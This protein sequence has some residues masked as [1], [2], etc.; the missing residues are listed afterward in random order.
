M[1]D[2]NERSRGKRKRKLGNI[3][4]PEEP[5]RR[6]TTVREYHRA[7]ESKVLPHVRRGSNLE[8]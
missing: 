3:S 4:K 5:V 2:T 8:S 7:H 1:F 6:P